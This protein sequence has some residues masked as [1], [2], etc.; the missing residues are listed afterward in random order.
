[1]E[2][3]LNQLKQESEPYKAQDVMNLLLDI[4][5]TL[6]ENLRMAQLCKAAGLAIEA[7]K[8]LFKGEVIHFTGKLHSTEHER[9]FAV[10]D[11][12]L[13]IVKAQN[14]PNKFF[15]YLNGQNFTD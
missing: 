4:L 13:E 11:A 10:Q 8:K 15:L 12:I 9:D 1:M 6:G 7:I 2:T 5:P 3:R 14:T